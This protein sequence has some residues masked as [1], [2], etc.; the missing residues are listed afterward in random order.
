MRKN[1]HAAYVAHQEQL[2]M[3]KSHLMYLQYSNFIER[4]CNKRQIL[5]HVVNFVST[6]FLNLLKK[7]PVEIP[8]KT[9]INIISENISNS[10]FFFK[11]SNVCATKMYNYCTKIENYIFDSVLEQ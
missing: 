6:V 11:R 1:I 5:Q 3:K 7:K 10:D 2:T 4:H 9:S 8:L